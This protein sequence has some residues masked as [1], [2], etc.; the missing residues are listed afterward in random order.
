MGHSVCSN[1][2]LVLY[3]GQEPCKRHSVIPSTFHRDIAGT[4]ALKLLTG[5]TSLPRKP[6]GPPLYQLIADDLRK[7]I[8]D[9]DLAA[10]DRLPSERELAKKHGAALMTA[11]RALGV[12]REEGLAESRRGSGAYVRRFRPI[13]RNALKRLSAEQWG[14]GRSIWEIDVEDR[15]LVAADVQIEQVPAVREVAHGLGVEEG[16]PVWRRSRKYLV[17][18]TPVMCAISHIPH[19]LAEGTRI[20]Q[21]DSGPGGIYAR[22]AEAGHKPVRFREELRCRMPSA[23]EAKDLKLAPGSPVIEINRYAYEKGDRVVEI[24]RMVLDASRYLLVYDFPS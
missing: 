11:R 1:L 21:V 18:D 17:D 9:G 19:D 24:N 23:A 13:V 6:G 12:L 3:S 15:D 16:E 10:G 5:G 14:R 7:R 8:L 20:T 2:M 4:F 22:L